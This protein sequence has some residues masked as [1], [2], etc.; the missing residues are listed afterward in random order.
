MSWGHV[1]LAAEQL[2]LAAVASL[3]LDPNDRAAPDRA[4]DALLVAGDRARR[5]MGIRSA[6]DRYERALVM[7]GPDKNW[8]ARQA[9]ALAGMG[10][11]RYWL[12][13]YRLA[14]EALTAAGTPAEGPA[15][16]LRPRL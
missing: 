7:A 1:S 14:P 4:A 9:R 2:E 16:P 13:E 10:E 5:R 12:G 6:I 8:G 15:R 3:D 11:S